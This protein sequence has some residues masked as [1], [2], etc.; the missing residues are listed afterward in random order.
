MN[1][2]NIILIGM[3]GVGKSSVGV[4]LAKILGYRFL[5]SDLVIQDQ[6]G[7]L[8]HEIIEELGLEG[9]LRIEDRINA[10]IVCEKSI[11]ATGGSAIYGENAMAHFKEI[12]TIV[13]LKTDYDTLE[14]RLGD[15]KARGVVMKEGQTF[16]ELF[17]ERCPL[18]EKYAD[19]IIDESGCKS[20]SE[21]ISKVLSSLK[22]Q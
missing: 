8:L 13:Y 21:T 12:G 20:V 19:I 16:R 2:R 7:K 22:S 3:P 11:V 17:D 10:S 5:D 4:V 6:E 15:L 18:Y 14:N 9:F 1:M